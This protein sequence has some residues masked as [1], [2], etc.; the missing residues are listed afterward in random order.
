M[1]TWLL[2]GGAGYIGSHVLAALRA[3][4]HD[5]VVLD[6]L[7]TGLTSRLPDDVEL[8]RHDL[9]E[10]GLPDVLTDLTR[11]RDVDGVVH[12]AAKKSVP[13]SV[14]V[15]LDYYE[16][17]VGGTVAMLR[18]AATAGIGRFV[19]SS[20][21]AVYGETSAEPV[22]EEHPT[23]PTSP[24]G[25]TKL[26]GEWAVRRYAEAEGLVWTAL[27]YFNVAGSASAALADR[28]ATNL[29]PLVMRAVDTGRPVQVFGDDW[30][31][32]DGT[33]LRDYVHVEDL[34]EAHVAAAAALLEGRS[35]GALN[36]GRNEGTSVLEVI[37][38]VEEARGRPVPYEIVARRPGDPARVVADASR[39]A[40][41]LGW[42]ASRGIAAM[43]G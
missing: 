10:P 25:E 18:A 14:A 33:C 15:P 13:E 1:S 20:S 3:A 9:L 17:N 40:T 22:A 42:R 21:A 39:I 38:A 43:A 41:V 11:R 29:L 35:P 31:T 30:P 5:A 4:G 6:D 16:H 28:G 36:V 19:Y 8:L 24:Y 37:R 2:T 12:L 27:R 23:L 34:A 7:S 32:P 26:A